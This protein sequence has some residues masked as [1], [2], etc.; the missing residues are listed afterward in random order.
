MYSTHP[1]HKSFPEGNT[2]NVFSLCHLEICGGVT[3]EFVIIDLSF[4]IAMS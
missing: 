1:I 4:I 2:R 3:H